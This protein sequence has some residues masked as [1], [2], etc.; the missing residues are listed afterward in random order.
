MAYKIYSVVI[1]VAFN[2]NNVYAVCKNERND[3]T[4]YV[5]RKV[6]YYISSRGK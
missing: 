4:P 1:H 6:A 5:D 2:E 3:I